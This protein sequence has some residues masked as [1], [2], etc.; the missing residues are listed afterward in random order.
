MPNDEPEKDRMDIHYHA[1][2]I[3]FGDRAIF[4]P[5]GPNPQT[6]IDQGTG[7]GIWAMDVG[8]MYPSAKV[9]G[10]DLSPIQPTWV[11]PNVEFRVDDIEKTW[12]Y[13]DDTFDLVHDRLGSGVAI[14]DWPAYLAEAYRTTKPGGWV[15]AQEFE[16]VALCDDGSVPADGAIVQWHELFV[17][18][19]MRAGIDMR[20]S[21]SKLEGYVKD[22][23][24]VN[25]QKVEFKLP[26]GPWAQDTKLR[27]AGLL[28]LGGMLEGISGLSIA[29]FTKLLGWSPDELEVLL[30]KVRSE[31]K[32][33][34]I[35]QYWPV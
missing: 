14:K 6:I 35:H 10:T 23:G 22:A 28:A 24:F 9:I 5:I 21:A 20:V 26:I 32:T 8:D 27:E 7:T 31:W 13:A 34:S 19:A 4:A 30:A 2:C 3:L 11:P 18:G 17:E 29:V 16:M 25:V 33:R 12:V 15:E 1:I